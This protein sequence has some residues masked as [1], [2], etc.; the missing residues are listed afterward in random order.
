MRTLSLNLWV[1]VNGTY[2]TGAGVPR[3]V[4]TSYPCQERDNPLFCDFVR[5]TVSPRVMFSH[6][7]LPAVSE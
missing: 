6:L 2:E 7:T 1:T 5:L 4:E 3:G